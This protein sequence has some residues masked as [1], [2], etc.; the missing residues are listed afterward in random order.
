MGY[1]LFV[2]FILCLSLLNISEQ[3]EVTEKLNLTYCC[4]NNSLDN[5]NEVQNFFL[6]CL[7][8]VLGVNLGG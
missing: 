5:P 6:N 4:Q 3:A 2:C 8:N 1:F 7:K